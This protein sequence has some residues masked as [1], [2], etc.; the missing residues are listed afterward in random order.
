MG[1]LVNTFNL[2]VFYQF[3]GAI[4]S[5]ILTVTVI[6]IKRELER[7]N[8]KNYYKGRT[9][10]SEIIGDVNI[11]V[12]EELPRENYLKLM[13]L[14]GLQPLLLMLLISFSE[15]YNVNLKILLFFCLLI[16][17]LLHEFTSGLRYSEN[18]KYQLLMVF[19]WILSFI[20]LS[21]DKNALLATT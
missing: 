12:N 7:T 9:E 16:F 2:T 14:W 21:L 4:A 1:I 6:Y 20:I 13:T 8:R 3:I 18:W 15:S 17:T 19:A 5:I 11:K 10:N